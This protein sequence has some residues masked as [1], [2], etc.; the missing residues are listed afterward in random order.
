MSDNPNYDLDDTWLDIG[1]DETQELP[2]VEP[3]ATVEQFREQFAELAYH[4]LEPVDPT[5]NYSF[6]IMPA[7]PWTLELT[8]D[9]W[10]LETD[11]RVGHE[12]QTLKTYSLDFD[13]AERESEREIAA[14]DRENLHRTYQEQGLDATMQQA[15]GI[16]VANG[17][18]D[19][20][21]DY[22]RL[23]TDGP[24]DRFAIQ[25]EAEHAEPDTTWLDIADYE[26][27]TLPVDMPDGWDELI[28][29]E[30]QRPPELPSDPLTGTSSAATP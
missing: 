28:E 3:D 12:G 18:L 27:Q 26:A 14:M 19:A 9:K 10:W 23:F 30:Q 24:P 1:D 13:E 17:E 4:L 15:Q 22:G 5:V 2:A 8:A 25:P 11:G 7:D 21:R 16:A 29:R 20:N 6:E